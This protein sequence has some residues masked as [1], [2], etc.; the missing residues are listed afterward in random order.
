[1]MP[2]IK[3]KY[4][5]EVIPNLKKELKY[6]TVMAV[7]KLSKIV[8]NMGVGTAVINKNEI[9]SAVKQLTAISGQ[10]AVKTYAKKDISNFKI[11]KGNAIGA[12]VTL[13]GDNMYHFYDRLINISL[14][15]VRDFRGVST[16]S[17][18]GR[19]NYAMGIKEQI[20]FPEI[21][22]DK[23]ERI[24]GLDIVINTTAKTDKEALGLLTHL[25]MPFT[26]KQGA[27]G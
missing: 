13:R 27:E 6:K 22:Y 2:R 7:P 14:P 12:K 15:N 10:K 26:K 4:Q 23:V 8:L 17:V 1:M 5:K 9:E 21:D 18:D 20:I 3:K 24:R 19:G 16:K 25:G 11:R